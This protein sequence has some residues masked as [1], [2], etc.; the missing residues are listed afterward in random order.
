ME[1]RQ[2]GDKP[3]RR[4]M[5]VL[6]EAFKQSFRALIAGPIPWGHSGPLCHALSFVV[7]VVVDIDAQAACDSTASDICWMGVRRLVV[8]NGPNIFQML[9]VSLLNYIIFT[10]RLYAGAVCCCRVSACLSMHSRFILLLAC[11]GVVAVSQSFFTACLLPCSMQS[12]QLKYNGSFWT[13]ND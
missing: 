5:A 8:A 12:T 1:Y 11:N 10:A 9:L 6:C 7:G 13:T 4:K 3:K 2:N